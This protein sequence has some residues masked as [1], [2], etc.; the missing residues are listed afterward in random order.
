MDVM[1]IF[2]REGW[3]P[4]GALRGRDAMHFQ[5]ALD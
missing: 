5:A 4:A 1:A 3:L 2:A